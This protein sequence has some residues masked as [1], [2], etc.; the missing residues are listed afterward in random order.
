MV[1]RYRCTMDLYRPVLEKVLFPVFEAVR[2]RPTVPL[3]Q[4]LRGS[5]HWSLEAL[6]DLQGGLLRRLIRHAAS[7][8]EHYRAVLADRGMAPEDV[9]TVHDLRHLPLLG[10]D[11]ARATLDARTAASPAWS[12][13][14]TTRGF[15]GAP[16]TVRYTDEA[17]NWRDAA[18]WRG[19][20]WAGYRIGMRA[21]HYWGESAPEAGWLARRKAAL[22]HALKRDLYVDCVVRSEP[23]LARAVRQLREFAPE[24]IIAYADGAAALARYVN[25]HSQRSWRDTPVIVVASRLWP[26]DRAQIEAAFGPAFETYGCREVQLIAAECETHDGMHTAME[27]VIVEVVV[28]GPGGVRAAR[29]G[30]V[31]EV[32]VTD[33]HNLACPMIRYL[34]GDLAVARSETRCA[35]GRGLATIGPIDGRVARVVDEI[36]VSSTGGHKVVGGEAVGSRSVM[37]A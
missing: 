2:G 10:R 9:T 3:L 8:T 17:R 34:T 23:A 24:V 7:R 28:R 35:C 25:Q 1:A 32:A 5:E 30:E 11:E 4:F 15:S 16:V 20:G 6:H 37:L 36:P 21:L 33:L 18:R 22:D 12:V 29:P 26:H 19:Y 31:G 13:E 27:N 14:T